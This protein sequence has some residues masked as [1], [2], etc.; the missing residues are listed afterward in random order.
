MFSDLAVLVGSV[1]VLH[2][3][4]G[5]AILLCVPLSF[6]LLATNA[7]LL[8]RGQVTVLTMLLTG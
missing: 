1:V 5:R 8:C 7:V 3:R 2:C 4:A 6:L